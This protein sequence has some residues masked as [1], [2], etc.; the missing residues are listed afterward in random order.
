MS[1]NLE[2]V[3]ERLVRT[4]KEYFSHAQSKHELKDMEEWVLKTSDAQF[5]IAL[6]RLREE[7]LCK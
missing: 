2:N 1:K 3:K 7:A 4:M 5:K 6:I